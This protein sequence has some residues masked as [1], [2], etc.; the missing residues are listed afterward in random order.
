MISKLEIA[1]NI[2]G[3]LWSSFGLLEIAVYLLNVPPPSDLEGMDHLSKAL[4]LE[5]SVQSCE[6]E[7]TQPEWLAP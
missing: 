7:H 4:N 2:F 5:P 3:V 6:V 1:L